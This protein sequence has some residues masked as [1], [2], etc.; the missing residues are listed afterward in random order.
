MMKTVAVKKS[1]KNCRHFPCDKL[2]LEN[3][4]MWEP[5][6]GKIDQFYAAVKREYKSK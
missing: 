4:G 5:K 1:C 3:R 2:C 6:E